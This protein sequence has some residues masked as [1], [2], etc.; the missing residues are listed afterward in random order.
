MN[1]TSVGMLWDA[2][3]EVTW[4]IQQLASRQIQIAW[5]DD[6]GTVYL[7]EVAEAPDVPSTQFVGSYTRT[8]SIDDIVDDL[9]AT[10]KE[11]VG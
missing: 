3:S 10:K 9:R 6:P 11:R 8:T 4:R 1:Y 2:L 5:A 7:A